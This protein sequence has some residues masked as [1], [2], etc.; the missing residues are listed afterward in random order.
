MSNGSSP[1][2]G[3]RPAPDQEPFVQIGG[4]VRT[5]DP[6]CIIEVMK[7]FHRVESHHSGRIVEICVEDGAMVEF[8]QTL[9]WMK[10][11]AQ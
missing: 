5:G 7:L 1:C 4:A 8:G 11:D 2:R 9:M 10:S 6:V 3:R